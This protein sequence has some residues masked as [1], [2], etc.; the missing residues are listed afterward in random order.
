MFAET[1]VSYVRLC[2]NRCWTVCAD[3]ELHIYSNSSSDA[4]SNSSSEFA[5]NSSSDTILMPDFNWRR[6]PLQSTIRVRAPF[7][8]VF[9][10]LCC[11]GDL[12]IGRCLYVLSRILNSDLNCRQI[13]A[14]IQSPSPIPLQMFRSISQFRF[15]IYSKILLCCICAFHMRGFSAYREDRDSDSIA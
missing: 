3:S 2:S 13:S 12:F 15:D 10:L 6:P 7:G 9:V 14:G 5:I 8:E 11:F 4:H 1:R